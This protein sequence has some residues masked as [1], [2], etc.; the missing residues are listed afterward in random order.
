MRVL[1]LYLAIMLCSIV[2][3]VIYSV[4]VKPTVVVGTDVCHTISDYH[5]VHI[6]DCASGKTYI[7][8]PVYS[9]LKAK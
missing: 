4:V 6:S 9:E 2:G 3:A 7:N 8:P 5:F 1:G